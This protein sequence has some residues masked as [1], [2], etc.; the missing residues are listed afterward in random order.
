[1]GEQ[2]NKLQIKA[3]ILTVISKLQ[4]NPDRNYADKVLEVL[5]VQEDTK[6]VLDILLKELNKA[7]EQKVILICFLL[8]KL[9]D[10]KELEDALWNVLKDPSVKDVTKT[11]VLN[12]LKDMGNKVNYDKVEEY[13][14]NPEEVIDADTQKLLHVAI[15][16]PE[17]QIDFLDFVNTLSE[18]DKKILVE[19]LGD[20]Y[21]SD[22]LANILNPLVLFTPTSDLGKIAIGIL[23]ETKSQ[24]AL[25]TLLE[26]LEFVED[27][28]VV[29]LIKKNISK[30]KISG[31]R[32]DNTIEFYK[33][34]LCDSKPY[35]SFASYPDGHGNQALIFSREKDTE[36]IQIVAIVINDTSG[37][38]DCFGFNEISKSE[39]ERIVDR[40][41][42]GDEHVYIDA[43]II[44]TILQTAEKTTRR[45]GGKISYEYICWKRLLSD[46][47]TEVV[48]I[49][50]ILNSALKQE[51]LSEADL[52]EIYMLDFVQRWF[53]DTEYSD[54][55]KSLV[56][57]L[58]AKIAQ[59]DFK[60]EFNDVVE[61]SVEKIFTVKQK[62]V[63]DK[64]I[65][66]S[67]YLRYLS[68]NKNEAALL[69][70]LYA[71]E[72]KKSK[73]AQNI[74]R[75]SIYEYYVALKFR[76]KEENKM[77][78]IFAMRN[79]TKTQ[80]LN[81][82]QIDLVISIIEGLWVEK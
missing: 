14:Q 25:N 58:N 63:L 3:E 81:P 53:F 32:E 37:I 19:S 40:F 55:F 22:D 1:M 36:A 7:D 73:L 12:L 45:V 49:E 79:K 59:N 29:S 60:F 54:E 20:D 15:V 11:I 51:P 74:V 8:I 6:A 18:F 70:S 10:S 27:E 21:S 67:A 5:T 38:I 69:F 26:A 62:K 13:F 48:P 72:D 64:R 34:I 42:N 16:N 17:A 71:D 28:E 57:D 44:K 43:H 2:L 77:T 39:F 65:L 52:E 68:G 24:L 4:A 61:Q 9:C 46:V 47:T 80:E 31:I 41:Y 35:K 82:K 56:D 76:L 75:K 23:G 33:S 78:N 50:L 66:M 30:L